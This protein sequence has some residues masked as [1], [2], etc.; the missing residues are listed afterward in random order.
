MLSKKIHSSNLFLLSSDKKIFCIG[1]NKTGTTSLERS[2]ELLKLGPIAS[3]FRLK[4]FERKYLF[5]RVSEFQDYISLI[6]FARNFRC[7]IDRPWN[8]WESYRIMDR[9]FPGSK[10]I[11]SVRN[12]S[13][14]W[15]SVYH[16]LTHK[17]ANMIERYLLHLQVSSLDRDK[18]ISAYNAYNKEV[19]EW[20][21]R[22]DNF[23]VMNMESGDG[24]NKLCQF[25]DL[26]KPDI[27]F[28]HEN[29]QKY[30]YKR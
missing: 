9:A 4:P 28:P 27:P 10:F 7:F 17:K 2:L 8:M 23:L 13:D 3:P 22:R 1:L 19:F 30:Y 29:K 25:L 21:E 16:W 20:F 11:L 26:P 15:E 12:A 5:N 14:W 6:E 24:W 18:F